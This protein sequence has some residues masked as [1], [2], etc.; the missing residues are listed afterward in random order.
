MSFNIAHP[1][2]R[3]RPLRK[4]REQLLPHWLAPQECFHRD[5]LGAHL[6]LLPAF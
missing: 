3:L 4:V 6:Q 5:P 1:Y 2:A